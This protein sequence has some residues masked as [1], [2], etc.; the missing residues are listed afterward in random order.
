M[1]IKLEGDWKD[2]E[3]GFYL[4]SQKLGLELAPD[5]LPIRVEKNSKGIEVELQD[6]CGA[7]RF[8]ERIHFFRALG[9]FVEAAQRADQFKLEEKPQFTTIGVMSDKSGHAVLNLGRISA[10]MRESAS[11][12]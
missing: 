12:G 1:K 9:L 4:I 7:I 8:A 6:G 10:F 11:I 5:G 2:L 3:N